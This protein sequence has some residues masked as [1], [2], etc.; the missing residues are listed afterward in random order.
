MAESVVVAAFQRG[1]MQGQ[2]RYDSSFPAFPSLL[3][4]RSNVSLSS[5]ERTPAAS[6]IAAACSRKVLVMSGRGPSP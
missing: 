3:R 2:Q 4:S 1:R 6:S 5:F